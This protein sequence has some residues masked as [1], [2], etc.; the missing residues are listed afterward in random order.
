M[1][2]KGFYIALLVAV[3]LALSLISFF[4]FFRKNVQTCNDGTAYNECSKIKPYFCVNGILT[5]KAS[6]CGCSNLS[7]V[8]GDKC[9]SEYQYE[10]QKIAL[11]FTLNGEKKT[12]HFIVYKKLNDY[13]SGLPRYIDFS[14]NETTLLDFKLR[15]LN[16]E[17]QREF[18][19]PLV[20][21]IENLARNKEDQARI[22]ISIIQ[23]IPFGNSNKTSKIG[24]IEIEYYRYP[25]EVLYDFQGVCGEKSELLG[26]LLR[27]IGYG[28]AFI[29]YNQENHEAMG[30]KCP[31]KKSLDNTGYCFIETTG[32]SIIT[33]YR[34]EYVSVGQ[35]TSIPEIIPIDGSLYFGEKNFYEYK[36]ANTLNKIR[37]RAKEY[38]TINY[39]QH[40]QFNNL[41]K[42]YGLA[43]F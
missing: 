12:I 36:D 29:Y 20:V 37:E 9:I 38:E 10:P 1:I 16:E 24:N 30:I 7:K 23:N 5:E 8:N 22:A 35:L 19:L 27:E 13:L 26:F 34:T 33:D 2:K 14:G 4:L 32:P 15:S 40:L 21:R 43:S 41:K 6:A 25:Y 17:Q 18:L 3:I 42:K 11:N 31:V 28:S 39:I